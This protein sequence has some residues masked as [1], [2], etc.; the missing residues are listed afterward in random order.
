MGKYLFTAV[1]VCYL[2]LLSTGCT[3]TRRQQNL[4]ARPEQVRGWKEKVFDGVRSMAELVLDEGQS[5]ESGELGVEVISI[6]S[7]ETTG[8]FFDHPTGP[9]AVL[10]FYTVPDRK[11]IQERTVF[12]GGGNLEGSPISEFGITVIYVNAINTKERWVWF[13]LRR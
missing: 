12:T 11:V 8:G 7:Y 5:S 4:P 10:R 2:A 6:S 3:K 13:D 9:T 1:L